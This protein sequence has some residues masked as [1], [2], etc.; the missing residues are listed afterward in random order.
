MIILAVVCIFSLGFIT[1]SELTKRNYSKEFDRMLK[2]IQ[3]YGYK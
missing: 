2:D 1:G 3:K